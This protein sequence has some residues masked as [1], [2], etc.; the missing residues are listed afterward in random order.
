MDAVTYPDPRVPE[1]LGAFVPVKVSVKEQADL[2]ADLGAVWTPTFQ[3]RTRDGRLA[4]STSGYLDPDAFLTELALGEGVV[5]LLERRFRD[6]EP[7]FRRAA[8]HAPRSVLTPEALYWLGVARYRA[9]GAPDGLKETW[10][11]LLDAHPD[12]PWAM[13]ASFIRAPAGERKQ[14]G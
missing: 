6:A 14:A 10:N 13:R 7:I 4:R 1:A 2:A 12:T 5:A 3:F 8:L 11:E 9:T